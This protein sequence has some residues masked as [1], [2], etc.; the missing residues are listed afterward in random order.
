VVHT[1]TKTKTVTRIR[2]KKE[3]VTLCAAEGDTLPASRSSP[4]KRKSMPWGDLLADEKKSRPS[5]SSHAPPA[6][7][8]TGQPWKA[9][10]SKGEDEE[11]EESG[12]KKA[13]TPKK[14]GSKASNSRTHKKSHKKRRCLWTNREDAKLIQQVSLPPPPEHRG[15][16][17]EASKS[18]LE[19]ILLYNNHIDYFNILGG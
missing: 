7:G 1:R 6:R 4:I 10:P 8:N 19:M 17:L 14:K 5:R 3:K 2:I 18:C 13:R 16:T 15:N 11:S 12:D 9:R